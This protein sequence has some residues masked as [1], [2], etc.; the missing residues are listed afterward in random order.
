MPEVL[1][2]L[3]EDARR[4]P[5][6]NGRGATDELALWPEEASF[7]DG[8]FDWRLSKA[9]VDAAGPFSSFPGFERLLVVTEGAGLWI[10]HADDAPRVRVRALEP[11]RFSGDW[12]TSAELVAGPVA[13]FNVL[14]RRTAGR[15]E[16]E[17]LRLGARRA[18]EVLA[19]G[20]AFAHLLTGRAHARL[21]G[22]DEPFE[23]TAGE[24]LWIDDLRGG[25]ELDLNGRTADAV[26]L[27][28]RIDDFS[29]GEGER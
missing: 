7:E 4:V 26:V 10:E 17:V 20:Q 23:L 9:V 12:S 29:L 27:L 1:H 5:W 3:P 18:R 28:V 21:T 16:V 6:R 24:S 14:V 15:A 2:L 11:Y 13:D 19:R 8:D 25:E 22:E